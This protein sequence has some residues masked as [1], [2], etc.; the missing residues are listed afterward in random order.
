VGNLV[1]QHVRFIETGEF[2]TYPKPDLGSSENRLIERKQMSTKT[3]FKRVALVAVASMGF[4]MLSVAPS[5]AAQASSDVNSISLAGVS[6]PTVNASV[7]VNFEADTNTITN[8]AT[9]ANFIYNFTGYLSTYPSGGFKQI[10]VSTTAPTTDTEIWTAG[11]GTTPVVT[12]SVSGSTYVVTLDSGTDD[13]DYVLNAATATTLVGAAQYSFT[14]T[15][16][17][18]Y[19]LT[20]WNDADKDGVIDIGEAVQTLAITVAA[21]T[22]Y[23]N[24]LSTSL[25]DNP[26]N[27]NNATA[28]EE[29]RVSSTLG[30][31]GAQI[32]VTVK[33]TSG[34]ALDGQILY[35]EMSGPGLLSQDG[36]AVYTDGTA[37]ST[38][39]TLTATNVGYINVSADGTAGTGTVTISIK[40]PTTLAVLGVVAT[41]TVYFHGTVA[42]L[43]A[44][45]NF[46]I[47]A[48][49]ATARGCGDATG[50]ISDGTIA[51][52]PFVTIVA[53]D[54]AGNLVPGAALA[55]VVSAKIT[56]TSVIAASAVAAVTE[57]ASAITAGITTDPNGLGY[58]NA[59]VAGNV[60]ATSGQS[61]T[62]SYRTLLAD[63]ATYV[64]S[65]AVTLSIG[66]SVYTTTLKLSKTDYSA[67]EAMVVT[68][69]AV[70][71]KGNPVYDGAASPEVS[72][73]K[74]VGGSSQV[75]AADEYAAGSVA[76]SS[77]KPTIFSPVATGDFLAIMS[78]KVA[79][80]TTQITAK[81]TVAAD[82]ATAAAADSAAE[83]TDA[84]NA[85]TDAANAAAE[86]ADAATAA[87]Q[88]A[89]DAVAALSEQFSTLVA[90]I[91]AQ[92]TSL[93]ALIVKIQKKMKA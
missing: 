59:S 79:G 10:A 1:N 83:A 89:S 19:V 80:V 90:S 48:A 39:A 34:G 53:K 12:E 87:A 18:A 74:A 58:F 29:S 49:S 68:I 6:T 8:A 77:T 76:T 13:E 32:K 24:T 44:T 40:D 63:G 33:N 31:N 86:A 71:S 51:E 93:T 21:A 17:G 73:S 42:T 26:D 16:A 69:T 3:T 88:D 41:E 81:A 78:G 28:D 62:V 75:V 25:L 27:T 7:T 22:G 47:A 61:T 35:A 11:T 91:K 37:R 38:S 14:P 4:G 43:V 56:D 84:A 5:S 2:L 85:A 46:N 66:G 72:F 64:T 55:N 50:C 65:N 57:K 52:T 70:D 9:D 67:A 20:V 23:S 36:S 54:S 82:A 15:V 60:L 30:T 45:A 92:I